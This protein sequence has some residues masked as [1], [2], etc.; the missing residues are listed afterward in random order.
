MTMV[1]QHFQNFNQTTLLVLSAKLSYDTS[2]IQ[3]IFMKGTKRK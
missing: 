3:V 1:V 2:H